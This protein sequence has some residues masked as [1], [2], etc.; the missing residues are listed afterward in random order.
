MALGFYLCVKFE[1]M[2]AVYFSPD[3]W[4]NFRN[5]IFLKNRISLVAIN[6]II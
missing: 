2:K 1:A 4:A 3:F 6:P 5:P